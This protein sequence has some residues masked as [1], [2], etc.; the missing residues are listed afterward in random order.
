MTEA[1]ILTCCIA[2]MIA[3]VGTAL[4]A[5]SYQT[6]SWTG[7]IREFWWS[8]EVGRNVSFPRL[9]LDHCPLEASDQSTSYSLRASCAGKDSLS[10]HDCSD[11]TQDDVE[12]NCGNKATLS[13]TAMARLARQKT[14]RMEANWIADIVMEEVI[15]SAVAYS[16][17]QRQERSE[18]QVCRPKFLVLTRNAKNT[19]VEGVRDR[20]HCFSD[21]TPA[22]PLYLCFLDKGAGTNARTPAS[23]IGELTQSNTRAL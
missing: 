19:G 12:F 17:R 8:L 5:H 23:S 14:E 22:L 13:E 18:Q 6:K 16:E 2:V 4:Y 15:E 1:I 7:G 21:A 9:L 11:H 20:C 3:A 10:A